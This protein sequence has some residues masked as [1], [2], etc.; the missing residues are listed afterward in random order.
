M[1]NIQNIIENFD[2]C[3]GQIE[4]VFLD[5]DTAELCFNSWK[6]KKYKFI[7]KEVVYCKCYNFGFDVSEV[8]LVN[9]TEEMKEAIEVIKSGGGKAE[10]Y[11]DF[12]FYQIN[13]EGCYGPNCKIIFLGLEIKEL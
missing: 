5:G 13:F 11:N 7:F 8:E 6:E 2:F 9:Q 10:G 3:D 12:N 4:S 1:S